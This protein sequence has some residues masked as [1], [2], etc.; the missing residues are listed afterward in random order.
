MNFGEYIP[1]IASQRQKSLENST[2]NNAK[3]ENGT[4]LVKFRG[5]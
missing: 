4:E 1:T 3:E 2:T 5:S